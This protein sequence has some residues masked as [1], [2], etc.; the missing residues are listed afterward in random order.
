MES[1]PIDSSDAFFN[2]IPIEI[3]PTGEFAFRPACFQLPVTYSS[4]NDSTPLTGKQ[5]QARHISST[6]QLIYHV[7][8]TT[9]AT[10]LGPAYKYM[11]PVT[12]GPFH[13]TALTRDE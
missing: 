4:K 5:M 10:Y 8:M 9:E 7:V 12:N 3:G 13:A 1:D 11:G 6:K 2:I